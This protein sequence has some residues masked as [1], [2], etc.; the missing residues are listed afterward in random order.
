MDCGALTREGEGMTRTRG[1]RPGLLALPLVGVLL[2]AASGCGGYNAPATPP[3]PATSAVPASDMRLTSPAFSEADTIP[4][5]YTCDGA[6]SF[7]ALLI[8][9]V[10]E[11]AA[12]L[13]V[14]MDDPDAP[15]ATFDHWVSYDARVTD[16]IP[17]DTEPGSSGV[18]GFGELG[19]RGPCPPPG[20]EHRYVFRVLALDTELG[21]PQGETKAAVLVAAEGSVVAEASLTGRYGT[22]ARAHAMGV[23]PRSGDVG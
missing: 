15:G 20:G 3:E 8:S 11:G 4:V 19:Y 21:L 18:N 1:H 12:T 5:E 22:L 23:G 2:L 7:P 17:A 16:E 6:D 10:P 9:G 13:V 14:V